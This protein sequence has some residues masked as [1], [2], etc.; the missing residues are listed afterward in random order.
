MD[1]PA[2]IRS[3]RREQRKRQGN[4]HTLITNTAILRVDH[5][6]VENENA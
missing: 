6:N 3:Q 5:N 2:I 4:T 1:L